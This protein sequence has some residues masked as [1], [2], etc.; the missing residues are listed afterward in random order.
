MALSLK[1]KWELNWKRWNSP[2]ILC[3]RAG[4]VQDYQTSWQEQRGIVNSER[5]RGRSYR[6]D[7]FEQQK[8]RT[9]TE[10][11]MSLK[12]EKI[13]MSKNAKT[14]DGCCFY[15]TLRDYSAVINEV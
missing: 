13:S 8:S 11:H 10:C 9:D 7:E 6:T 15:K 14:R 4:W 12:Q 1:Y 2:P 3:K 5:E